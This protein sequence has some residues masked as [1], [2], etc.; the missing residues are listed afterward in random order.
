MAMVIETRR[1]IIY[2]R[3]VNKEK[4]KKNYSTPQKNSLKKLK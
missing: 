3:D 4:R 2:S 1:E